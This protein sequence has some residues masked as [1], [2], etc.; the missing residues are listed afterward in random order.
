MKIL[1]KPSLAEENEIKI[2]SQYFDIATC[3][4]E[5]KD[6]LYKNLHKELSKC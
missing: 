2:A 5:C 6:V 3:R 4:T 1:F